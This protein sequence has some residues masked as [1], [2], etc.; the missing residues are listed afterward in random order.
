MLLVAL[1][2]SYISIADYRTHRISNSSVI[3]LALLLFNSGS[4]DVRFLWS[5]LFLCVAFILVTFLEIGGGDIKLIATLV[6]FGQAE[7][8]LTSYLWGALWCTV[9]F[10]LI[11]RLSTNQWSG[12]IALAPAICVPF[13]ISL[14]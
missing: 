11:H 6:A 8:T 2:M 5:L 9:L 14:L 3:S 10:V 4:G 13:L 7:I 12:S 1:M